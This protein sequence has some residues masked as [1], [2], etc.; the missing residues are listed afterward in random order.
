MNSR[1]GLGTRSLS[2]YCGKGEKVMDWGDS[3]HL[4]E[5][6]GCGGREERW[7]PLKS[8][9]A[10]GLVAL[11][12]QPRSAFSHYL[13]LMLI[14]ILSCY[15][16]GLILTDDCWMRVA[17]K[18]YICVSK[19]LLLRKWMEPPAI[20]ATKIWV[21]KKILKYSSLFCELKKKKDVS[22][23]VMP[24]LGFPSGWVVKK[25]NLST[26]AGDTG[27]I[28]GS[29]RSPGGGNGN[30]LKYSCLENSKDRGKWQATVH[31]VDLKLLSIS[32]M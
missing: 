22:W 18:C 19:E 27:L 15:T 13:T 14:D 25:K 23:M 29:G 4:G 31:G 24:G 21:I 8:V 26:N 5:L 16:L 30:P 3:V 10:P 28:P 20:V 32:C 1:Q 11:L 12:P 2:S 6:V 17:E 9:E 7:W